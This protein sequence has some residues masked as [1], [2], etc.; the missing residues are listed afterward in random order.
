MKNTNDFAR[1]NIN[2]KNQYC[3]TYLNFDYARPRTEFQ[4]PE[5]SSDV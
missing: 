5:T 3:Y 2:I 4:R 1:P